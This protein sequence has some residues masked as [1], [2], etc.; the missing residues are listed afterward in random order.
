M[1]PGSDLIL[2]STSRYRRAL[3]DRLRLPYAAVPPPF[4][5]DNDLP[6]APADLVRHLSRGKAASVRTSH[7]EAVI[8]GSDQVL[9]IDGGILGKPGTVAAAEAQLARMSGRSLD[10]LTGLCVLAGDGTAHE[11]VETVR[12]HVRS[13]SAA[14]IRHYVATDQPLDCAGAFKIESLGVA[15][16]E[17]VATNDPTAIEGLPLMA[18]TRILTRLGWDPLDG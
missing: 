1:N 2:A 17:K 9:A 18:L 8:I 3:L 14:Q 7:P 13:L 16:F 6:L 4:E 11:H 10:L 12:L 15:L 5:E